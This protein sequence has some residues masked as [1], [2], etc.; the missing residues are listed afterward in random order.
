VKHA[1]STAIDAGATAVR[2]PEQ[3]EGEPI[4]LASI[5]DAEGNVVMLTQYVGGE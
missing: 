5:E 4:I 3:R 1:F 2:T